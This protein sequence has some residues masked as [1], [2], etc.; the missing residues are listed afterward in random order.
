VTD[1]ASTRTLSFQEGRPVCATS[2]R[3]EG[4]LRDPQQIM[5]DIYDLFRWQEG[6]FTF[7]QRMGPQEGC[8]VLNLSAENLILAGA[9]W[10]D[11]WATI[12]RAVPSSNTIFER[13][14]KRMR[15]GDL[16]MTE[17]ERQV[18]N[19]LDGLKDVTAVARECGLTEFETSKILY[20]LHAVGLVQP[21]D[22]DKIRLRRVFREFAELMCKGTLPYRAAPDDFTCEIEVN[23]RC[24][25]LPV[26]F[27]TSRIEDHTDPSL[28]TEELAQVYRTFLRTQRTV[29][30]ER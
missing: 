24:A 27:I 13:R 18:L 19:S 10:V 21:G 11:N 6:S 26:R 25:D 15:L 1:G 4:D 17:E 30:R 28:R 23:R 9:R 29:V 22:L 2:R 7:D 20:G 5:N 12:Q 14:D 16:D 8:L 3:P